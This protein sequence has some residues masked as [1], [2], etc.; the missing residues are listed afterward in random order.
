MANFRILF[1][2]NSTTDPPITYNTGVGRWFNWVRGLI[3]G[4]RGLIIGVRGLI[5]GVRGLIIGVRG[6]ILTH[7]KIS[8]FII[9]P[10]LLSKLSKI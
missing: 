1:S 2:T 9:T 7:T 5:I 6:A 8:S 3:I 10:N 4:I